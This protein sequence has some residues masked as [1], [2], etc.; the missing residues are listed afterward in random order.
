MAYF[1]IKLLIAI[2]AFLLSLAEEADGTKKTAKLHNTVQRAAKHLAQRMAAPERLDVAE[3]IEAPVVEDDAADFKKLGL[4]WNWKIEK[5]QL[6]Q[7]DSANSSSDSAERMAWKSWTFTQDLGCNQYQ[8]KNCPGNDITN[9]YI[10]TVQ[11]CEEKCINKVSCAG[12]AYY[13]T[14]CWLKTKLAGC[15]LYVGI[16][17]GKCTWCERQWET[18]CPGNDI[19]HFTISSLWACEKKCVLKS[20]C[21]GYAYYGTT[22]YL[23]WKTTGCHSYRGIISGYCRYNGNENFKDHVHV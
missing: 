7:M 13:G 19:E 1:K 6:R 17:T 18:N 22:C 12:Y 20:S 4:R 10:S 9:F 11:G 14:T 23:K 15:H 21:K 8:S 3:N 2:V 5:S 16:T